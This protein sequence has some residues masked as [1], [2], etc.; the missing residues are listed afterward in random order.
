MDRRVSLVSSAT[1]SLLAHAIVLVIVAVALA[2]KPATHISGDAP[3]PYTRLVYEATGPAG[4]GQQG[5]GEE[6]QTPARRMELAGRDAIAIPA[7]T[8][9][10]EGQR[11]PRETSQ[12]ITIP[13]PEVLSGLRDAIGSLSEVRPIESD[14]RGAGL[15]TGAEGEK[16][17][18]IGNGRLGGPG[19]RVGPGSGGDDGVQPGNGVS[20]PRLVREV[21]PNYS[22]EALRARIEGH[23]ELEIVVLPDGSVGRIRI[24]R[25][26]DGRFGLDQEA[27]DAVRRWRFEPGRQSGK[28]VAVRVPVELYFTLR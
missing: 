7:A 24:V 1:L 16:G 21:K 28:A 6:S 2:N 10:T 19:D 22:A 23:V 20:W 25:S 9:P 13:E 26:L 14:S 27:I 8:A 18:G 4:G 3:K 17:S 12:R 15:G 5:G 11:D